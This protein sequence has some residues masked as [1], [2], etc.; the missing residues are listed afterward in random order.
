MV[1]LV[2]PHNSTRPSCRFEE[3]MTP[4]SVHG[5]KENQPFTLELPHHPTIR[6][7]HH[8]LGELINLG[9]GGSGFARADYEAGP[10]VFQSI[11][12]YDSSLE[13]ERGELWS[14]QTFLFC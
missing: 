5:A 9:Y 6:Q 12:L 10:Q 4:I 3:P 13:V 8:A 11:A 2:V 1:V 14:T 7:L